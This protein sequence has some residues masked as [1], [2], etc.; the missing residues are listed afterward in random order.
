MLIVEFL[1]GKKH[2]RIGFDCG[3]P[4]LN[5][6]L[7]KRANQDVKDKYAQVYVIAEDKHN[8]E[9]KTIYGYFTLNAHTLITASIDLSLRKD[10]QKYPLTPAILLGRL[11]K[12]K[13]QSILRGSELLYIALMK[14]NELSKGLG[15]VFVVTHP[16]HQLAKNFYIKN[17]FSCL[18]SNED[19][20][21]FHLKNINEIFIK[22]KSAK[23]ISSECQI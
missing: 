16:K 7:S 3:D 22:T 23:Q 11:A 17:G 18:P 6:Y 15:A 8:K 19:E 21:V 5:D 10:K 12:N 13:N 9:L 2:D 14:A 20:L 1:D 4:I